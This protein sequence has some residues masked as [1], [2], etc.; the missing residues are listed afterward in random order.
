[1]FICPNCTGILV[2]G[3][4]QLGMYW[5][6]NSCGGRAASMAVLRKAFSP[7]IVNLAWR[8]AQ[9]GEGVT[10]RL[11]PTCTHRMA[12]V[13]VCIGDKTWKWDVCKICHFVWFDP[14]EYEAVPAAS[15]VQQMNEATLP[16]AARETLALYQ[17]QR[18]AEQAKDA[19]PSPDA[20]WKTIPALFGFPVESET[21]PL[22]CWPWLTWIVAGIIA[23]ISLSAFSDLKNI[24]ERFALIPA[25]AL[26]H[27]GATLFTSFF[28]HGGV[29]HLVSNLYFLL[30]FG[31]NVEDY[32]GRK[33]WLILL[34]AATLTGDVFHLMAEPNST[35]PCI[36]ASGGISG[37]IA[38]YALKFPHA[39]LGFLFR[40]FLYFRWFQLPAWGAFVLWMLLQFWG[41]YKQ[42][43]GFSNVSALAH[44]GGAGTGFV[45]WLWWRNIGSPQTNA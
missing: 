37:L 26:R 42:I 8:A 3:Q 17:V 29:L 2:R 25:E 20:T 11:C 7:T 41:A 30:I 4:N 39:R 35:T 28:L 18:I 27:G 21:A 36:G 1:M 12:E 22:K 33:R 13:P 45:M 32:L 6:C 9:N 31:D 43:A 40:Y 38:F 5:G 14:R 19:D 15:Q 23:M 16:Q 44:L 24:V 34:F 10:K